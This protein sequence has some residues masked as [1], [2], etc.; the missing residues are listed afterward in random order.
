MSTKLPKVL[1][2]TCAHLTFQSVGHYQNIFRNLLL[3]NLQNL[4]S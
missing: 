4:F 1:I 2:I 3:N